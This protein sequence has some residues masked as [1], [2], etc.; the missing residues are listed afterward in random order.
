M[1]SSLL[2]YFAIMHQMSDIERDKY[3]TINVS[4]YVYFSIILSL[5]SDI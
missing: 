2:Y 5:M 3:F 1:E 4:V